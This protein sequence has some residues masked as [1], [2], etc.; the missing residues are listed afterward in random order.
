MSETVNQDTQQ[1]A[2]EPERTFTQSEMDA[3]I[4]DRLKREREKYADY[5]ALK[6]KAG[7]FDAAEEAQKSELQKATERAD[8]LQAQ[9][10]SMLKADNVRKIREKVA[11]E[12]GVPATLLNAEDEETCKAQ[13][14]AIMEFAK[15]GAYPAVPDRGEVHKAI[16]G[17]KTRDQFKDWFESSLNH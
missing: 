3:I 6:E 7:R 13:A 11:H 2:A 4:R 5:D 10:D 17:G 9:L 1:T 15:P 8:A 14:K 16:G 12:T